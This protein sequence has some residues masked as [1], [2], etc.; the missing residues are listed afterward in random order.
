M[1]VLHAMS[2]SMVGFLILISIAILVFVIWQFVNMITNKRL[3]KTEKGIW[4]I[5]FLI[6]SLVTAIVWLIVKPRKRRR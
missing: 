5:A 1:A 4:A 2:S 3:K 6:A